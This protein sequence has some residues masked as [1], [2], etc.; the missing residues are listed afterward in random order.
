MEKNGKIRLNRSISLLMSYNQEIDFKSRWSY[1]KILL[2]NKTSCESSVRLLKKQT[3]EQFSPKLCAIYKDKLEIH[4]L[5]KKNKQMLLSF[6]RDKQEQEQE[7]EKE[8]FPKI[9]VKGDVGELCADSSLQDFLFYFRENNN[10][11][12]KIIKLLNK[13]EQRIFSTFLCH[14]F[15]ENFFIESSEQIEI[16][17]FIYL[18]FEIEIDNLLTPSVECFLNNTFL[19]EFLIELGHKYEIQ[20]YIDIVLIPLI[21]EINEI[22]PK[23]NSLDIIN[24]SRLHYNNYIE[25]GIKNC[26]LDM[27]K[28]KFICNKLFYNKGNDLKTDE[29]KIPRNKTFSKR[30]KSPLLLIDNDK[31]KYVYMSFISLMCDDFFNCLTEYKLKELLSKEKDEFMKYF[32]IKQLNKIKASK[33]T[34]LYNCRDYYFERIAKEGLI[35]KES[36]N[37]YQ[38]EHKIIKEFIDKLLV[39]LE[40][41]IIIPYNIKAICKMIYILI[42]KKFKKINEME[43]YIF[44]CRFLFEKIIFPILENPDSCT[45]GKKMM[46]SLNTRKTL[47]DIFIVLEKLIRG[48]LFSDEKYEKFKVFNDFIID[49]FR[50]L[51]NIINNIISNVEIPE[52]LLKLSEEFYSSEDFSLNNLKRKPIETRYE[53]FHEN[54][55]D[56]MEHKS[57][58]FNVQLLLL[59]YNIVDN[60]KNIFINPGNPLEKIFDKLSKYIPYIKKENTSYYVIIDEIYNDENKEL[61]SL[62]EKVYGLNKSKNSQESLEKL[63]FCITHL[64]SKMGIPNSVW[65]KNDYDTIKT[66]SSIHNYLKAYER[67]TNSPLNW[68][69]NYILNNLK[70]IDKKYIENNYKLL[71]EEIQDD[72]LNLLEKLNKLNDFLTVNITTKMFLIEKR[73]RNYQK[74]L[75]N[76]KEAEINIKAY[77]FIETSNIDICIMNGKIYNEIRKIMSEKPDRTVDKNTFIIFKGFYCPHNQLSPEDI[78]ILHKNGHMAEYHCNKI[79]DFATKFS[80]FCDEIKDE[81]ANNSFNGSCIL[82]TSN[83]KSLANDIFNKIKAIANSPKEIFDI[84]MDLVYT[85][86]QELQIYE[87]DNEDANYIE[88]EKKAKDKIIKIVWNYILKSLVIEIYKS[89]PIGTDIAFYYKCYSLSNF[90]EPKH[91]KIPEEICDMQVFKKIQEHLK[92]MENYRTPDGMFDELKIS[93][94]LLF[95]LYK[96]FFNIQ[97]ELKD[98]LSVIAYNLICSKLKRII[99]N[100][101]FMKFFFYENEL[102][103]NIGKNI[104]LAESAINYINELQA[105]QLGI[106]LNKFNE[107]LSSIKITK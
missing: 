100:L 102:I 53:Y 39:N 74:E 95:L 32:F 50:K 11:M 80:L 85:K 76:M 58:C 104:I 72:I 57:I 29:L 94:K 88:E 63:K 55:Y 65:V 61:L 18:L 64:L 105:K 44:I 107:I 33:N 42:K 25:K 89:D 60:H 45:V 12:L 67:K 96:F 5:L 59:F 31:I 41:S 52:K 83:R 47:S 78:E 66:F 15:Y 23:Y 68:H 56:F 28:Q 49:R 35:S 14:F 10:E 24:N 27:S 16:L 36:L 92:N 71:Y 77:L 98:I 6:I 91:L 26:F 106:S 97:D 101:N 99:F 69:S 84:Y 21:R 37:E 48:E 8:H 40:K 103:E 2:Q 7:Q 93:L 4:N 54:P 86:I 43:I 73:K 19:S 3:I 81:I 62:K 87:N 13:E 20:S 1:I 51:K 22:Y 79:I 17:Y 9:I 46:I 70:L 90:V 75:E 34:N 82:N 30:I 38:I